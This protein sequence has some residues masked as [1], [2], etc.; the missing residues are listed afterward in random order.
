M[1]PKSK[2][3]M[4]VYMDRIF[5]DQLVYIVNNKMKIL[6]GTCPPGSDA[7]LIALKEK[8]KCNKEYQ[9]FNKLS[10]KKYEFLSLKFV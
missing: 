4:G 7:S 6:H 5:V 9:V 10:L 1:A 3:F 8:K 2:T